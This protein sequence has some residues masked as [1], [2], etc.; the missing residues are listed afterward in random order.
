MLDWSWKFS[1]KNLFSST[2]FLFSVRVV[3]LQVNTG[4]WYF[5]MAHKTQEKQMCCL[6]RTT[7]VTFHSTL[8]NI[9]YWRTFRCFFPRIIKRHSDAVHVPTVHSIES[10]YTFNCSLWERHLSL[11]CRNDKDALTHHLH[12]TV[13]C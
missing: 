1:H 8:H 10:L 4:R 13:C 5:C 11:K 9:L 7:R 12:T 6:F 3:F 2:S